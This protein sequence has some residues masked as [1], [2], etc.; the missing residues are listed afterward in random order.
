MQENASQDILH[1]ISEIKSQIAD[2]LHTQIAEV[3]AKCNFCTHSIS[4]ITQ[5]LAKIEAKL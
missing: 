2:Q 5:R 1:A 3:K 4:E